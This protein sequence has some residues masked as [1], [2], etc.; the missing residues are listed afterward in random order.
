MTVIT[1]IPFEQASTYAAADLRRAVTTASMQRSLVDTLNQGARGGFLPGRAPSFSY[2]GFVGTIG[3]FTGIVENTF[4]ANQGEYVAIN[5]ANQNLTHAG[6]SGTQNRIDVIGVQIQDA[7]YSGVVNTGG[8]VIVQGTNSAGAPTVP[9]LPASFVPI[10]QASIPALSSTP[11]VTDVRRMVPAAGGIGPILNALQL[12][13]AGA[14][15]GEYRTHLT[16][17]AGGL[18]QNLLGAYGADALWHGVQSFR[19]ARPT[20]SFGNSAPATIAAN[21]QQV[22]ASV[23]VPD[24]GFPYYIRAGGGFLVHNVDANL[25]AA[26]FS[27]Q[28]VIAVDT[29]TQPSSGSAS[30]IGAAYIG[31]TT[32]SFGQFNVPMTPSIATWTGAHTVN[33]IVHTGAA[34]NLS[35]GA[36]NADGTWRFDVEI[37]PA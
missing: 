18:P 2:A 12:A 8:L 25:V 36:L 37:M 23:S 1:P 31:F 30:L 21:T 22:V 24:P 5:T 6:S 10:L 35:V 29:S 14:F 32:A 19:L 13:D 3:L 33:L 26:S 16:A 17:G 9:T 34:S 15:T 20:P 7:F 11:T 4:G 28:I 27:H